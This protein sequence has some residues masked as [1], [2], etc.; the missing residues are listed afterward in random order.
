MG[1]CLFHSKYSKSDTEPELVEE[2][3]SAK[4]AWAEGYKPTTPLHRVQ[5]LDSVTEQGAGGWQVEG[6]PEVWKALPLHVSQNLLQSYQSGQTLALYSLANTSFEVDFHTCVQTDRESGEQKRIR[7]LSTGVYQA[8]LVH[9]LG[10]YQTLYQWELKNGAW[11]DFE[12]D[13]QQYL[14]LAWMSKKDRVRYFAFG[15]EYEVCFLRMTLTNLKTRQKRHV[16]VKR[17][18]D[19]SAQCD[20]SHIQK[21]NTAPPKEED[22]QQEGRFNSSYPKADANLH[23]SQRRRTSAVNAK[24]WSL[25]TTRVGQQRST[26]EA[27]DP[28]PRGFPNNNGKDSNIGPTLDRSTN[29]K[30]EPLPAGVSLPLDEV[31]RKAAVLQFRELS[32]CR[33]TSTDKEVHKAAFRKAC[34][35]WHPD[36][37]LQNEDVA[38]FVFQFLQSLRPWYFSAE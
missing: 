14:L 19:L 30:L 9:S 15:F 8:E 28:G 21:P 25:G 20:V 16:R 24:R 7:W 27:Q 26:Q 35:L 18:D 31:A 34:L 22:A 2:A 13:E 38:T 10:I 6:S 1:G 12:D 11:V 23:N 3:C 33:Q 17:C 4:P 36:K 5:P 32:Q 37:N 29:T